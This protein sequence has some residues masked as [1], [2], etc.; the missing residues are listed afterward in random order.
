MALQNNPLGYF[1][2]ISGGKDSS[3]IQE[4]C[5]MADV[6][7]EF[8]HNHTSVDHPETVYFVRKEQKRIQGLGHSFRIQYP[9]YADG[10]QKTMW[11]GIIKKGLPTRQMRWCCSELKEYGGLGRYIITGVRWAES[12]KRRKRGLHEELTPN[13]DKKLVLNNDNDMLRRLMESCIPKRQFVLNPIID[14][15]DYDVWEFIRTKELPINPLYKQGYKRVGCIGCP[16]AGK[17]RIKEFE[18]NPKYKEAYFRAVI[19]H[20]EYRQKKGLRM[21]TETPKKYFEWWLKG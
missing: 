5:I 19:K 7:C 8:V 1:V 16:M 17:R 4:L 3:V 11:N 9:R 13:K 6:K 15:T 12:A 21:I 14:W 10:K 20:F 18:K 2:C